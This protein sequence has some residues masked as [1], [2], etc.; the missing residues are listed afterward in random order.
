MMHDHINNH[1]RVLLLCS[2]AALSRLGV[3]NEIERVLE[4]EAKEGG[5]EILIP[6]TID[7]YVYG[8]WAP[9]HSDLAAQLRT[10]VIS[11]P[12]A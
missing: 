8:D 9:K 6:V 3:L 2:K 5:N 1:D 12:F 10:R 7:D 4:R 11:F